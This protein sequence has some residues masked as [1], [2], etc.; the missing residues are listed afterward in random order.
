MGIFWSASI[1]SLPRLVPSTRWVCRIASI[2]LLG[3]LAN[4]TPVLELFAF[5]VGRLN[6]LDEIVDPATLCVALGLALF[7]VLR[8]M[9]SCGIERIHQCRKELPA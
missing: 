1:N 5:S 2:T 6:G 4:I 8:T 9:F 7:L 3:E